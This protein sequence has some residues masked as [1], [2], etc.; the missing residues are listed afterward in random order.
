[1]DPILYLFSVGWALVSVSVLW[2]GWGEGVILVCFFFSIS[3]SSPQCE[4]GRTDGKRKLKVHGVYPCSFP[5]REEA[6]FY[7]F[8]DRS[9][10]SLPV[11]LGKVSI[12]DC[13]PSWGKLIALPCLILQT[14][15]SFKEWIQYKKPLLTVRQ[16]SF[17]LMMQVGLMH[18]S[19]FI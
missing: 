15:W 2:L 12:L 11:I 9:K 6:V 18:F 10:E 14:C 1:M 13:P 8:S 19:Q 4:W 17:L 7:L 16:W 5:M 3:S